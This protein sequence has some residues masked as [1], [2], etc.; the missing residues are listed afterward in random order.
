MVNMSLSKASASKG[1]NSCAS[2]DKASDSTGGLRGVGCGGAVGAVRGLSVGHVHTA[3]GARSTLVDAGGA[4][5][6]GAHG[7]GAYSAATQKYKQA[8]K[9]KQKQNADNIKQNTEHIKQKTETET[10]TETET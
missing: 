2:L 3:L 9:Q 10:E 5:S 4:C 7:G 6:A 1:S 8:Q